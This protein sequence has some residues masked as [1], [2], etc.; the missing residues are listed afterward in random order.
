MTDARLRD[1]ERRAALDPLERQA[2]IVG[3]FRAG[4]I[5]PGRLR[6]AAWLQDPHALAIAAEQGLAEDLVPLPGEDAVPDKEYRRH[7]F[8]FEKPRQI[9]TFV[10]HLRPAAAQGRAAWAMLWAARHAYARQAIQPEERTV[11][12][13]L[14]PGSFVH[15]IDDPH[16]AARGLISGLMTSLGLAIAVLEEGGTLTNGDELIMD[17]DALVSRCRGT[18]GQGDE[19]HFWVRFADPVR[20]LRV[21]LIA[22]DP[23]A[24]AEVAR[25]CGY[26]YLVTRD[27]DRRI[28]QNPPPG[29]SYADFLRSRTGRYALARCS[30]IVRAYLLPW[31][32][33]DGDPLIHKAAR[34]IADME[35]NA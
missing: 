34:N 2:L 8:P 30:R 20:L 35:A 6:L 29:M 13:I 18:G 27:V 3:R 28:E 21:W 16:A 5:S 14:L 1:L 11:A 17:I 10:R 31:A 32:L 12:R 24:A 25:N 23:N 22:G 9:T 33:G 15:T 19:G 26:E 7:P 4:L